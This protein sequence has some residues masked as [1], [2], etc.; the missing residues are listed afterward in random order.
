[1]DGSAADHCS[2]VLEL[3]VFAQ[4]MFYFSLCRSL[5]AVT[6]LRLSEEVSMDGVSYGGCSI[7]EAH[8]NRR[9]KVVD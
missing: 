3:S 7:A 6:L 1:M 4:I 9:L 5:I 8:P 2:I